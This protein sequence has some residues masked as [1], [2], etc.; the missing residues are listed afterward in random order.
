MLFC[1]LQCRGT[2]LSAKDSNNPISYSDLFS[3]SDRMYDK[4]LPLYR[5]AYDA[6]VQVYDIERDGSIGP[7]AITAI[8]T[9]DEDPDNFTCPL[10]TSQSPIF[11]SQL[12]A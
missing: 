9:V 1:N 6:E 4:C 7:Q 12:L 11:Q 2:S 5:G 10:P 8:V 3:C